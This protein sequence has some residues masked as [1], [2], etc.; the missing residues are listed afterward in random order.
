MSLYMSEVSGSI[1]FELAS[2]LLQPS[3]DLLHA[4]IQLH[5][6]RDVSG[7]ALY[8]VLAEYVKSIRGWPTIE[9]KSFPN[10][11]WHKYTI[12]DRYLKEFRV[13]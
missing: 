11:G 7:T 9:G 2:V 6:L 13:R 12:F 1:Y 10:D 8:S 5:V 3:G 4:I